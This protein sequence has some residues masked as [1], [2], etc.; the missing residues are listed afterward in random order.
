MP[1]VGSKPDGTVR[2]LKLD[3]KLFPNQ[4]QVKQ[5]LTAQDKLAR[6]KM[7]KWFNNKMKED[8][9]WIKNVW[10]SY[11][12]HFHFD[13]LVNS[14]NC[15]FWKT[16]LPQEILQLPLHSSKVAAWWAINS[17]T[18]IGPYWF[19]D[20]EG[21]PVTINQENYRVVIQKFH[22]SISRR[23][24]IVINQQWFMQDGATPHTVNAT[25]E[26]LTRK[27]GDIVISRKT[28][29]PWAAHSPELNSCDFFLWGY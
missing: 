24:E 16:E 10:F 19:E 17:K 22:A 18:I 20:D 7:C 4:I 5:K 27:L 2:I 9:D 26:L 1:R 14:K 29:N 8:D 11:D 21:G 12:T 15:V 3:L 25:L 23:R 13:S 28:D 6:V